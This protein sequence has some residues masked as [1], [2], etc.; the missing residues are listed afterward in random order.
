MIT[1]FRQGIL[2]TA[3]STR[4]LDIDKFD[5]LAKHLAQFQRVQCE[6]GP[7]S[8]IVLHGDIVVDGIKFNAGL[9]LRGN[10]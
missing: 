4:H 7:V 6:I 3:Y 9:Y 8:E 1:S 2:L 10:D 5:Q